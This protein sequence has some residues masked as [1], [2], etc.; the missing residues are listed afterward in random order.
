M[1][2]HDYRKRWNL[3]ADYPMTARSYSESRSELAKSMGFG[4]RKGADEAA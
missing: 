1:S 4:K 3:P 2:P